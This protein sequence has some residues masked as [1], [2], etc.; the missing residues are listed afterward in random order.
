METN[1]EVVQEPQKT[2]EVV[3][4]KVTLTKAE[5][6]DLKHKADVSSQNFARLKKAE[7][8]L[9]AERKRNSLEINTV[10]SD[11]DDKVK[12]LESTVNDLKATLYK[13]EVLE[14]YPHLKDTWNDFESFRELEDNKGMNMRTAAKAFTVEKGLLEPSRKGLEKPTGGGRAPVLSAMS[15]EEASKLRTTDFKKYREMLKNGQIKV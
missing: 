4:E 2:P 11:G 5:H 3:E 8:D 14:A 6:D 12:Q 9:E 15:S 13:K 7:E 1:T 10:P